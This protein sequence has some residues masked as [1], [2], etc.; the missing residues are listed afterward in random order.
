MKTMSVLNSKPRARIT[1]R[2]SSIV[3]RVFLF[4]MLRAPRSRRRRQSSFR[5]SSRRPTDANAHP[6][7]SKVDTLGQVEGRRVAEAN[8]FPI[9]TDQFRGELRRR[10]IQQ[11]APFIDERP[12]SILIGLPRM[13]DLGPFDQCWIATD[14]PRNQPMHDQ[15]RGV[16]VNC[17]HGSNRLYGWRQYRPTSRQPEA[18]SGPL[19]MSGFLAGAPRAPVTAAGLKATVSA[20]PVNGWH[21]CGRWPAA[22]TF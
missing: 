10:K 19:T 9:A 2:S 13:R 18:P 15:L 14:L 11:V 21:A 3:R 6:V 1:L 5:H 16:L 12:A 22:A 8:H 7:I 4:G 17:V 20:V